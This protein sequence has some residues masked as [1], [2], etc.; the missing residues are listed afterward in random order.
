[1]R[2][3]GNLN[4]RGLEQTQKPVAPVSS[5][6]MKTQGAGRGLALASGMHVTTVHSPPPPRHGAFLR[7]RH[8]EEC[9]GLLPSVPEVLRGRREEPC[10]LSDSR[11]P[12]GSVGGAWNGM[13]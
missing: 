7:D 12:P 3:Y 10:S 13:P 5:H 6:E 1:M 2:R 9:P 11:N 4:T 8:P